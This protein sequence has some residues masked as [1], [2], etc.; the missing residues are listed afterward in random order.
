MNTV[1][2]SLQAFDVEKTD[3]SP[4][5]TC[6]HYSQEIR[7][8]PGESL[9]K[10]FEQRCDLFISEERSDHH[11]VTTNEVTLSY[12][13]LDNRANQLARYLHHQGVR[14]GDRIGLLFDKTHHTYIAL[15]AVLKL[16]AAYIPLDSGFP[17]ERIDF[18]VDDAGIS[19]ILTLRAFSGLIQDISAISIFLDD[20]AEAIAGQNTTR[21]DEL[22]S[23]HIT[24][25]LAYIIYT[26]GSTGNPKGVAIEHPSICNFVR[27]AG[28]VYGITEE[29]RV[30]QG[31]TIAFDFS[32]EE[33]WVPLIAGATL[34]PG[35]PDTRL[36]GKDLSDF[37]KEHQ[38]T[39][40]CC[41]PTLLATI[42]EELP[43]LRFLLVSGEACP[44][45]LVSRW[46]RPG[47][48]LFNAYGPTE[49]TVTATWTELHPDRMVTIGQPLPTYSA[50]ILS[51]HENT[52]VPV[53]KPGEICIAGIGL[54][55]GYINLKER[56]QKSFIP[57]FLGIPNNVSQHIYRTGDLGRIT[58]NN[59]IEY[60]GRIDTQVKIRGYRIELAEVESVLLE[61]PQ[62]AQAV[63]DTYSLQSG[64]TELVAY[65]TLTSSTNELSLELVSS[66]LRSRLPV[67]MIPAYL[68]EL[69]EIPM[70]PSDKVDRK[71]LP[72]PKGPRLIVS[73]GG[74]VAA[75]NNTERSV[76][77]VVAEVFN[78]EQISVKDNFFTNL[79]GHSLM[80]AVISA[81]LREEFDTA[82]ISIR[83][84]YL[85]PTVAELS[86]YIDTKNSSD[87]TRRN[88]EPYRIPSRFAYYGCGAVQLIYYYALFLSLM[89]IIISGIAWSFSI[90]NT[91]VVYFRLLGF[92]TFVS[93]AYISLTILAKW[94]LIGRWKEQEIPIWSLKYL[95]FWI[96][97]QLVQNNPIVLFK[98]LSIYN[99]Y[100]RL[101]GAKIGKHAVIYS[102]TVPVCT[103][104]INIGDHTILRQDSILQ[105]YKAQSGYIY[106][107][108][109]NIGEH[110]F[111]GEAS[112]LDINTTI[113]NSA[114]LGHASSLQSYQTIPAGKSF[115]GSPA[116]ETETNYLEI[117]SKHCS[118]LRRFVYSILNIGTIS[119]L[120]SVFFLILYALFSSL[121]DIFLGSIVRW[122]VISAYDNAR[123]TIVQ[124][125]ATT[126]FFEIASIL[127]LCSF[128]L[129]SFALLFGLLLM[130]LLPRALNKLINREKT[131]VLYGVHYYIFQLIKGISNSRFF[132]ILFGDSSYILSYLNLIGCKAS[133]AEQTGSNL[134]LT[135]KHDYPLLC[136]IGAGTMISDG[137]SMINAEISSSSFRLS[138]VCIHDHN[139]FGNNV[140]YPYNGKIG[141]NCLIATKA[142]VPIDGPEREN[143]GILGSPSFEIPRSVYRDKQFNQYKKPSVRNNRI[144]KKNLANLYTISTFLLTRF[145]LL[146]LTFL[147][148]YLV[149][150][151]FGYYG[152]VS[153]VIYL[154]GFPILTIAY[155]VFIERLS[156]GFRRLEPTICSIYDDDYWKVEHYWK[157][158]DASLMLLFTGTP[159]KNLI[160][161]LLGVTIGKR[162]FDDGAHVSEKTLTT[163]GDYCTL[164]EAS[165]FQA[166]SLEDGVF[167][168]DQIK[169]G[170]GCTIGPNAFIHYGVV[171]GDNV[172]LDPDSFLMKGESPK[173]DCAWQGNP[174]REV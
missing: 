50:V 12:T 44:Q 124:F 138:P 39:A 123:A 105:G 48:R 131:Y 15:L 155:L 133:K 109:V 27:V 111:V 172:T 49:T 6:K 25:E 70:L 170:A 137:L 92:T 37:L 68:E 13:E 10:L 134:G 26:S 84:I 36:V 2:N 120:S 57:D 38:V 136:A 62:I 72:T 141:T 28:E 29:D 132:N 34:I 80:M 93:V 67:Y 23:G 11:A 86:Q 82:E 91:F 99:C 108:P 139:F 102:K 121:L 171:M 54:A 168:A 59:E 69:A 71:N 154:I 5:L 7:Y 65:Y 66:A 152:N 21:L 163:I 158:S 116:E 41:V 112:V 52:L 63:V 167:K 117:E 164:N 14:P 51:E 153:I 9:D 16:K 162:V 165:T 156:F 90:P 143:I 140:H 115:H 122:D 119:L 118:M 60:L 174:A 64:V 129:F 97:K 145:G 24:S 76:S 43:D 126:N 89:G 104:L 148:H 1:P 40:L 61:I 75:R 20:K 95:R 135:Q 142:M 87:Q 4:V 88:V 30:Y 149:T 73:N 100:L 32:V 150:I 146:F 53:G 125:A 18:I 81:K 147:I 77:R 160:S 47:R 94:V 33:I 56:T 55:K 85:N 101:L 103:D 45:D 113:E 31:M 17:K 159:M 173:S 46:Y 166:H 42:E 58:K 35:K 83:D 169:I 8:R 19:L 161:K 106:T 130:A 22:V 96:V 114:Q 144:H 107:G 74:F 79:G 128:M 127:L 110:C 78:M 151:L 157:M 98:G 3:M